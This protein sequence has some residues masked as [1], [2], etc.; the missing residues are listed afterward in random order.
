MLCAMGT[1]A[2]NSSDS[3]LDDRNLT[4]PFLIFG[5]VCYE[6]NAPCEG[7]TV[8]IT[9]L[10]TG[11][12]WQ[13][14]TDT[15]YSYYELVLDSANVTAGVIEFNATVGTV[16]NTTNYMI[17][18]DDLTSGGIFNFNL[19]LASGAPV[20]TGDPPL[21][22]VYNTENETQAFNIT[23][24]QTVNVTWF[25]NRTP[26]QTN[27]SITDATYTNTSAA[28]GVWNVSAVARNENGTA[29]QT[30]IWHVTP[31][32]QTP[33]PLIFVLYGKVFYNETKAPVDAPYVVITNLKTGRTFVADIQLNFYQ[34]I[35]NASEIRVNDTLLFNAS[36]DGKLVGSL[37]RTVTQNESQMGAIMM[38]INRGWADLQVIE[39]FPLDYIFG[40]GRN[41]TIATVIA[42]NGTANAHGFN[43]SLAVDGN[44]TDSVSIESLDVSEVRNVT[45]NW[46]P[47]MIG[48]HILTVT[49]DC[50]CVIDESDEGNNIMST[51]VFV[52]VPDLTVTD[53]TIAGY[54]L[55]PVNEPDYFVTTFEYPNNVTVG[56]ANIGNRSADTVVE[57]YCEPDISNVSIT[58]DFS[59]YKNS[60]NDTITQPNASRI[61][62]H[63]DW[64]NLG[65]NS[66]LNIYDKDNNTVET[67]GEGG[68]RW[69]NWVDGDF[70]GI[71]AHISGTGEHV[72]F[73]V[74]KYEYIFADATV[75]L[76]ANE[77]INISR[78]WYADVATIANGTESR[79][80]TEDDCTISVI[81]DP[82]NVVTE[83]N[84]S[85]NWL[86]GTPPNFKC[87]HDF[88]VTNITWSPDTPREG[89]P[90]TIVAVIENVGRSINIDTDAAFY[91]DGSL[92]ATKDI[93]TNKTNHVSA[94]W[95]AMPDIRHR[96]EKHNITVVV[97]PD[98]KINE[99]DG[100]NNTMTVELLNVTRSDLTI[101]D[102]I[103]DPE[104]I[105]IG[106][107][108][109]VIA[110]I[111]NN[112][113][114]T[115]NSTIW[116][117]EEN[118]TNVSQYRDTM[119]SK[120]WTFND[121][122]RSHR[123]APGMRVHFS[124]MILGCDSWIKVY[125]I[126]GRLLNL[127][128]RDTCSS[129]WTDWGS[130]TIAI[131]SYS[132]ADCGTSFQFVIDKYQI[133]FGNTTITIPA[134]EFVNVS[135]NW[136][137]TRTDSKLVM[138]TLTVLTSNTT[139]S[140]DVY[141][142][143][144]DLAVTDVSVANNLWDGDLVDITA[145]VTNFGG[146]DARNFTLEFHDVL[147]DANNR[148]VDITRRNITSLDAGCSRDITVPWTASLKV[149]GDI[150]HNHR[151]NVT[152]I[153]QDS[154]IENNSTNNTG[155]SDTIIVKRSR[156]FSVT[157]IAF[158]RDNET[159]DPMHLEIGLLTINTSV[160][161]T[162][163]ASC[164][165]SV[166][167]TCYLDNTTPINTTKTVSFPANNGTV[168]A[169]F[170][171]DVR[172]HG[173][174][175]ITVIAD[176]EN[177]T[178]EFDESNNA[179]SQPIYIRAPDLTV[180]DLVFDPES[181]VEGD[182]VNI[183][184]TVGN[185]GEKNENNVTVAYVIERDEW[186][187]S[188][189]DY[190]SN[191]S[192][193]CTV[194]APDVQKMRIHFGEIF[195][196]V[197]SYHDD[198]YDHLYV[199][200]ADGNEVEHYYQ[201]FTG[202][203]RQ[204]SETTDWI[205]GDNVTVKLVSIDC[206]GGEY[207]S[208]WGF[209]IDRVDMM[210]ED[211]TSLDISENKTLSVL[212]NATQAGPHPV[213]VTIDPENTIPESNESNNTRTGTLII[214]GADLTVSDMRVT[215]NG[216]E[217]N[218]TETVITTGDAVNVS[219]VI[220]NIGIRP[221]SNFTV[222]FCADNTEFANQTNLSLAIGE[223]MNVSA[224]WNSVIG[225]Y[226]ITV[227]S[228]SEKQICETDESNN[229]AA[230]DVSVQGADLLIT[231]IQW[232][233][234]PPD[235]AAINNTCDRVYDT[236]TILINV[237][238]AN[239]G[240]LPAVD[241]SVDI[242]YEQKR[243]RYENR[244][245]G[246]GQSENL[247]MLQ[248]VFTGD[249]AIRVFVDLEDNVCENSE[250][251]NYADMALIVHPSRDFT[252]NDLRLSHNESL[253]GVNDTI[254]D[255][256]TVLVEATAGMG[257][258]ESDPY[259]EY[260]KGDVDVAIIDE[261]EWV[262]ASPRFE[263]TPY[264]YAHVI[265]YPG[266]DAI[267]VHFEEMALPMGGCIDIRDKNGTMLWSYSYINY[268]KN[269]ATDES[270][271]LDGDMVYIYKVER[272]LH[273][274]GYV[275]GRITCS[276]DKYQYKRLDHTNVSLNAGG[277]GTI[278]N[279]WSVS[280]G[281][282]TIQAAA[283]T[284]DVV[285]EINESNNKVCKTLCVDACKDPAVL[286]ITFDP[287]MPAVGS[288][289]A[290][291]ATIVNKGN[292]TVN[293]TVDLWAE[294]TEYHPFESLHE[295]EFPEKHYEW[296]IASTY[297]DADWM[298]IHFRRI[299]MWRKP[300]AVEFKRD[301]YLRD[302][303]DTMVDNFCGSVESDVW[304]W[305][306]GNMIKLKTTPSKTEGSAHPG[307]D[308]PI[309]GFE[310][311]LHGYRI[312]LNRTTLTLA[313]NETADVAGI[314]QNVRAGNRSIDYTIYASV[315]M[316]NT[317]Y[318][319]NESNNEMVRILNLA[320]PDF[321]VSIHPTNQGG[322]RAK[323]RNIGFGSADAS[324]FFSRD[325][326]LHEDEDRDKD[327]T[328]RIHGSP[329]GRVPP[330]NPQNDPIPDD[331]D[332]DDIDWTRIHFKEL[333]IWN[334]L[335]VS[336]EDAEELSYYQ[337]L[338]G[339]QMD[340]IN[341]GGG[342]YLRYGMGSKSDFWLPWVK[343]DRIW[344]AHFDTK[345]VIDRYE[346]AEEDVID[347][348][349]SGVSKSL[350]IP[351]EGYTEPYNL[352]VWIDPLE[353]I[354][355]GN[356]DNNNDTV[357]VYADLAADHIKFVSPTYDKLC[358]DMEG[359]FKIDGYIRNGG[360]GRDDI[361]VPVG[362]F[363]VTL[364][365]RNWH[366]NGVIGDL[367]FNITE[368]VEDPIDG[369]KKEAIRFEFNPNEAFEVGGN[370]TVSL[371]VDSSGDICESNEENNVTIFEDIR[372][373]RNYV[374]VHN[375]SGYTGGGDLIN[376]AQGEVQGRVVYTVDTSNMHHQLRPGAECAV[377]FDDVIPGGVDVNNDIE[378]ARLF[379]YW[380][381]M[382]AAL[383]YV[384]RLDDVDVNFNGYNLVKAGNYSDHP[385]ASLVDVARGL[386]TYD[387][388]DCLI[389]EHNEATIKNSPDVDWNAHIRAVGLLVVYKDENEPLTKYWI[390]EGADIMMAA[391][392]EHPTGLPS[393]DCITTAI[394]D[395]V[396]RD[397]IE[398]VNATLLT[399]IGPYVRYDG[400]NLFS[401]E[402]DSLEFNG[403]SI[404]SLIGTGHWKP[405]H[406]IGIS[407]TENEWEDVTD[408]LK[409]GNN[410]VEIKSK[411]NYM[412]PNNAF[413]RLIFP[414]DLSVIDLSAPESTVVGAHHSI[415]ATIRNDGRSDVHDFN[416]TLE[417]DGM[418]MIRIPHLDLPA[419]ESMTLH[420]YNWTPK[421]LGHVYNLTAAADVL[422]GEDWDEIETENNAMTRYVTIEQG[423]F[424]N[425]T[426]PRGTGGGSNPTGGEYTE[427]ITGRVMKGMKEFL[428]VGGGGGAGM[429]SALE[430]IM[431]GA[432][433]LVLLLFVYTGYRMEQRNYG[434]VSA[435]YVEG[436]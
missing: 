308:P 6:G 23:I 416:M 274:R 30:W 175:T 184:A 417:I 343:T 277:T 391:N 297:P 301:L 88:T 350:D 142:H 95:G 419:G 177:G 51:T 366:P 210:F 335:D 158:F 234:I 291:N 407:F 129:G 409:R 400:S 237:R 122:V 387:V 195:M 53:I 312:I 70:I 136:T 433:W 44:V 187:E 413:L 116:F 394:F 176:P 58:R 378:V 319:T 427:E 219:A 253:I 377:G 182:I 309:W 138:S 112:E 235:N 396:E 318:E 293:F 414:P 133:P 60:S 354:L 268:H 31:P 86:Y 190:P 244:S 315:D 292:R 2:I 342:T 63:F 52:G 238:I 41:N 321:T 135:M 202:G 200:D 1:D 289:V 120:P 240:I 91:V 429:F 8:D 38:D 90:V 316:D 258:N 426:G 329:H 72:R 62:V 108:V 21:S 421:M 56:V 406:P 152:V 68:S 283:D 384:P 339:N 26:V 97:D 337:G 402:G 306:N 137:A 230:M 39:I 300:N 360:G 383:I 261:H 99:E 382:E 81:V 153:P 317:V 186:I 132:A 298:A 194:H 242:F 320:V 180:T 160:E 255:G 220:A 94:I 303:N 115:A 334:H 392:A 166:N 92:I 101:T 368:H 209:L 35:T 393:D 46:I 348:F 328:I 65:T 385:G 267:K 430:W 191:W 198:D 130:T 49:A 7:S 69:S 379:V 215:A 77:S 22:H 395:D 243:R 375:S 107:T 223:S 109:D 367:V 28:V 84:D 284:E 127:Y 93:S 386:Y 178:S 249:H 85:N 104:H 262:N 66:Y 193:T 17:T 128:T 390:N 199:Y 110:T 185:Q 13:A 55:D 206:S 80:V 188:P 205:D 71:Y 43:V 403:R 54:V 401:S 147:M 121:A 151:I 172:D 34:L 330:R 346:F 5:H 333:D 347:D 351:W 327:E 364:E 370:Y 252:V 345:G 211:R 59:G 241:F 145:R 226:T 311:D 305:V 47:D 405:I 87:T 15:N 340:L 408:H 236:D 381:S 259:H 363:N 32:A 19:M 266:A 422:S 275:F 102:I 25:V 11:M 139:N 411:G 10:N 12:S 119:C 372:N 265:T 397:D 302:N 203:A 40:D 269:G 114:K 168:Y 157:G 282:H 192:Y 134:N 201:D 233:V 181:P 398:N 227:T 67:I 9:N 273:D 248:Q 169:E 150:S 296:E 281:N 285:G 232:T 332:M 325:V 196:R 371:M 369:G 118:S 149:N 424:G 404:G 373:R 61:R 79:Y 286:N 98:N 288:D 246:I 100:T 425:S 361:A 103:T 271:W 359:D 231:S 212:W 18:P 436:L 105:L 290:I 75:S 358:L 279:S 217:I 106:D 307:Y 76:D 251:N 125:D 349:G 162:N 380:G 74:G 64:L 218:G 224:E 357:F 435:G 159:V 37:N 225:N 164:G 123:D 124:T 344:M 428:T 42:N 310:I 355:E 126:D 148:T 204:F 113:N 141:V 197:W 146:M 48:N 170:E 331:I 434:R 117:C 208:N 207:G 16:V 228:D 14:E 73:T 179:F 36:K 254:L 213:T 174:H 410:L 214:Q 314:L 45:F 57:F 399:V 374:R 247:T 389:G 183:T 167:L 376:V 155:C 161:I 239:Q 257:I 260:R 250:E 173:N 27:E 222:S 338:E 189:H 356:E 171:W 229:T 156:D 154:D 24:D 294:K 83:L 33:S 415:N 111:R 362:D 278:T 323:F 280:A 89:E 264:G 96:T 336:L 432:V 313:P 324:V 287:R 322:I 388:T 304:A 341:M 221:A 272:I 82:N 352:T 20:I 423:G 3:F 216:T 326:W 270:P 131:K 143:G 144:T 256:G 353:E 163:L 50:D 299:E 276:I 295:E 420:L 78:I 4:T 140:T 418:S 29:M 165:G 245:I 365:F 412:M 263:L 431:K